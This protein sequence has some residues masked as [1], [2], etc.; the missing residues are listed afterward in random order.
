MG[1]SS[2][3]RGPAATGWPERR[4]TGIVRVEVLVRP[5]ASRTGVGG[6]HDG[7]LV[8]HVAE[9]PAGGRANRAA[10]GALAEAFGVRS[11][12]V[13]LVRGPTSKRKTIEIEPAP[14]GEALLE[15]RLRAL[16]ERQG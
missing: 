10:L 3:A 8:V 14:G 13:M 6:S 7:A 4:Q 5:N 11:R 12:H 2:G 9:P 15:G 1:R 16:L